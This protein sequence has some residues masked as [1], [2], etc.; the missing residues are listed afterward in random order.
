MLAKHIGL[1]RWF[2]GAIQ[3]CGWEAALSASAE[4]LGASAMCLAW[5]DGASETVSF[6]NDDGA[7]PGFAI[8]CKQIVLDP[9]V[10]LEGEHSLGWPQS[11]IVW[12]SSHRDC[13]FGQRYVA[14][15]ALVD[16]RSFDH[17][18]FKAIAAV[19]QTAVAARGRVE[20]LRAASALKAAALD[21]LPCGVAIIDAQMRMDEMN[22]AC[23]SIL[24]RADG[25]SLHQ[26]RLTCRG[27]RDQAELARVIK[28]TLAGEADGAVVRIA[29]AGG[30]KPYVI[31][32]VTSR[33]G[34]KA[35]CVLM[36]VDPD[37]GP[38]PGSE[39]WRVMF[40]L[41]D[42]ELIIAEGLVC[43][44]RINDIAQQRGVSVETVRTQIKRMFERLHVSSQA[45]AAV[46]LSRAAPFRPQPLSALS[47]SQLGGDHPDSGR[48]HN[49][50]RRHAHIVHGNEAGDR[51]AEQ[52]RGRVG[53][54]HPKRGAGGDQGDVLK[55]GRQQ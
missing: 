50:R 55:P 24:Q 29:R 16:D 11:K 12:I 8:A 42:C 22:E 4:T 30:A 31:R 6:C 47:S 48:R 18:E 37:E 49:E 3:Q 38:P 15:F 26:D 28:E 46:R 10:E 17:A 44:R 1:S 23:R 40:D 19:A 25:L 21:Q 54:H 9:N 41:T 27:A 53:G 32:A 7:P 39:I 14:L 52:H 45:E 20:V 51:L 5:R 2:D 43:G 13:R 35:S 33:A 34:G 36:I